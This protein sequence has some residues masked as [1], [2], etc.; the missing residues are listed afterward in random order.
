[1][2]MKARDN[3]AEVQAVTDCIG[4][5]AQTVK[6][7]MIDIVNRPGNDK[8][9]TIP[10]GHTIAGTLL[11]LDW[12][13]KAIGR[14]DMT[15][16]RLA[17]Q[18]NEIRSRS[19]AV[20]AIRSDQ[21][22]AILQ[23][24]KSGIENA[25]G[26]FLAACVIG[27]GVGV[28]S[29]GARLNEIDVGIHSVDER[30]VSKESQDLLD[31]LPHRDHAEYGSPIN[32]A[33]SGYLPGTR[34]GI[35]DDL[36]HWATDEKQHTPIYILSGAAGTGKSTIAYEMAK[37]LDAMGRLGAS[38]FFVRGDADLSSTACVFSSIAYQL[39][40][41][42]PHLRP[43]I[44]EACRTSSLRTT[45]HDMVHQLD[46]Y[47]VRPL[48]AAS[49]RPHPVLV[50]IDALDECTDPE[51]E[52]IPRMLYLL[53]DRLHSVK[54]PLRVLLTTRPELHI[55]RAFESIASAHASKPYRLHDISRTIVDED[56]KRFFL[57]KLSSMSQINDL[58]AM[59]PSLIDDLTHAAEGL[60]VYAST[61]V[62]CLRE[63]P[64]HIVE[65]TDELLHKTSADEVQLS[66][67]DGLYMAVLSGALPSSF[68]K[69][70]KT[71][72]ELARAVLAAIALLQDHLP[73]S[74]IG[75]LLDISVYDIHSI[76]SRLGSVTLFDPE[77]DDPVRPL[78]A[79]FPQFL[80]DP[81]RC[82]SADYCISPDLYHARLTISCLQILATPGSLRRNMLG[83]DEPM[84]IK[85]TVTDLERRVQ[86][87]IP[88]HVR[89]AIKHWATHLRNA[90]YNP[91]IIQLVQDFSQMR[92]LLWLEAVSSLGRLDT[93]VHI[94]PAVC[95]WSK[96]INDSATHALFNDAYRF[97]L[98]NFSAI[99][100]CPEQLYYCLPFMP[101]CPLYQT[102]A[103]E[104]P[105][106]PLLSPR[107]QR[108]G[109]CL[110]VITNHTDWVTCTRVSPN[111]LQIVSASNDK[112]IR[113]FD[114][115]SGTA[116]NV[117][118]RHRDSVLSVDI[119]SNGSY[120]VSLSRNGEMYLWNAASGAMVK[121]IQ[122]DYLAKGE[123][124][125]HG[126][127]AF[128]PSGERITAGYNTKALASIPTPTHV[129]APA[130]TSRAPELMAVVQVWDVQNGVCL[131]SATAENSSK[132][133]SITY[134]EDGDSIAVSSD[135][136]VFCTFDPDTLAVVNRYSGHE[137]SILCLAFLP[138]HNKIASGSAD[139]T[140]RIWDARSSSCLHVLRG[141]TS[142]IK[143]IAVTRRG[144]R[145]ASC[146]YL[147]VRLW[148][149]Q[150]YE[151]L[152][153]LEGHSWLVSSVSFSP[154]ATRLVSGS[155][156]KSVRVWDL[157]NLAERSDGA[158]QTRES[159]AAVWCV[160][161]SQD[162]TQLATGTRDGTIRI[163]GHTKPQ[164]RGISFDSEGAG[165]T[166]Q[167]ACETNSTENQSWEVYKT[168]RW[169]RKRISSIVFSP[170]GAMLAASRD[171]LLGV[172]S[173][174]DFSLIYKTRLTIKKE[175]WAKSLNFSADSSKLCV[176]FG[177]GTPPA[178]WE[179]KTGMPLDFAEDNW[180]DGT[181]REWKFY[182]KDGW[183]WDSASGKKLCWLPAKR[184]PHSKRR[185]AC[186]GGLYACGS[187]SGIVT[188]LDLS[189]L[190]ETST[191]VSSTVFDTMQGELTKVQYLASDTDQAAWR[192]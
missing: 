124:F 41:S 67:L 70:R 192:H 14:L 33:K 118:K 165:F 20:K 34:I 136:P 60:F 24:I 171:A 74:S 76:L 149:T 132:I 12:L 27:I 117:M 53:F 108:W 138:T 85:T 18:A 46:S 4:S 36:E 89:Y 128:S 189:V 63:D 98:E 102:Y 26:E 180:G 107:S 191:R 129:H 177:R 9:S 142:T 183:I 154:D 81:T 59:R 91:E 139:E 172:W 134:S 187:N 31:R 120:I 57:D 127:V 106:V 17:Q 133:Y 32:V 49:E 40:L 99:D 186:H 158:A 28:E 121:R 83:L 82:T 147:T 145:I 23:G 48:T 75:M 122:G 97:V 94:L 19:M 29:V 11:Q 78:H 42:Q 126:C 25:R 38:F 72:R 190:C 16:K 69:R 51:L 68:L 112:T 7:T 73:P 103:R 44:V 135:S 65:L 45:V 100:S 80:I 5:L 92:L 151:C 90:R 15:L 71:N 131:Q 62:R 140:I 56:I 47:I 164:A 61:V 119:S 37:R 144:D 159:A 109:A 66:E 1:M 148:D 87:N 168:I 64:E 181:Q 111:G 170:D 150:S 10:S 50:I 146:S 130:D 182:A 178:I 113:V 179:S 39:A 166:A 30:T 173:T 123:C 162:G 110:R 77:T 137:H 8:D 88:L 13:I 155:F 84:T 161:F 6:T 174:A 163:W 101:N 79:S 22:T 96:A 153:T 3:D 141:Q 115:E 43:F 157:Q 188:I 167:P 175:E 54:Y 21:N 184:Q 52:R 143:S 152:A 114:A 185:E 35:L 116:L 58:L 93:A 176:R 105:F 125:E 169:G 55:E 95:A 104:M 2:I 160:A 86:E 156:D